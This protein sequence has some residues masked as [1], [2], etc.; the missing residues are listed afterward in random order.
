MGM[1]Y[2]EFWDKP[3]ILA[4]AYREAFRLRR[5]LENE[6]AW[7]QG[8]YVYDAFAVVLANVFSK[9]GSRKQ[10]YFDKPLDIYPLTKVEAK[11]REQAEYA[12]MQKAMEEMVRKQQR[13]KKPK[14]E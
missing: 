6:M 14:G 3:P 7:V 9:R 11:R 8:L 13:T 1:S 4:V 5:E 12:K 2:E 10:N